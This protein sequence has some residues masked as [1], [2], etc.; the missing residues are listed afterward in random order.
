M[1]KSKKEAADFLITVGKRIED[2][3][4]REEEVIGGGL[5]ITGAYYG[6]IPVDTEHRTSILDMMESF[7]DN[8]KIIDVQAALQYK[9]S[10]SQLDLHKGSKALLPGFYDP[11][12]FEEKFLAIIYMF[13][14]Q[15]HEQIVHD[16]AALRIPLQSHLHVPEGNGS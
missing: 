4:K 2:I 6:A 8:E 16:E 3:R 11:A 5:V 13:K 10:N 1:A 9:V 14:S 15:I 7:E 12:P